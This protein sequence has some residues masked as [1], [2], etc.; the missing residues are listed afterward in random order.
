MLLHLHLNTSL[1]KLM[2]YYF[3]NTKVPKRKILP[4][5]PKEGVGTYP[6][7]KN[8]LPFRMFPQICTIDR[9]HQT[10]LICEGKKITV[11][12]WRPFENFHFALMRNTMKFGEPL[13]RF[14]HEIWLQVTDYQYKQISEIQFWKCYSRWFNR[15]NKFC[16]VP[17]ICLC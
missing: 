11:S 8:P 14:F 1:R 17:S 12:K 9:G 15:Q 10:L 3:Y 16:S 4:F 6:P 13:S 2:L 7:L 5:V